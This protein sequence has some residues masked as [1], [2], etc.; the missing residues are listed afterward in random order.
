KQRVK[1]SAGEVARD[2]LTVYAAREI[3]PGHAYPPD[4]PWQQEM[5]AAFP[6]VETADQAVTI[7]EVKADMEKPRP[8]DRLVCGDVGFGKTEV[9]VRAA[10]KAVMDGK[11]VALLVPT[12]VLAEQHFNTFRQRMAAFPIRVEMLSRFRSDK[13]QNDVVRRL[14]AG[15]VDIV[16]GTHRLLQKDV[17]FKELGLV[18][19][20]EEQR[21]GVL[22]KE[23]LK[24]MRATVDVRTRSATP[25]PRTL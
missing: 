18:I 3:A 21:F 23:R 1:E 9:A 15:E 19:I 25:I 2:L 6:Y 7:Q 22:H 14:K 10:F 5:E 16:I 24:R 4:T 11:Q 8:M 13:E 12:T 17:E 20:D